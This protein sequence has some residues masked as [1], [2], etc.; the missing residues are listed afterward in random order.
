MPI[1]KIKISNVEHQLVGSPRYA[2]CSTGGTTQN[3]EVTLSGNNT[4]ITLEKGLRISVK[5]TNAHSTA[6]ASP[7]LNVAGTGAKDI[8]WRGKVLNSKQYW[9][10]GATLDFVYNGTQWDLIDPCEHTH[11]IA[12]INNLVDELGQM[13]T[14]K[15]VAEMNI[16]EAND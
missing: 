3:K 6:S 1:S 11:D 10:A 15:I 12:D 2:T 16:W 7:R 14:E 13:V 9:D 8:Y 5:F 4:F